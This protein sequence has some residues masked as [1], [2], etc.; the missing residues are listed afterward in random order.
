MAS[1]GPRLTLT[2]NRILSL[3][4]VVSSQGHFHCLLEFMKGGW[5]ERNSDTTLAS[6]F[7]CNKLGRDDGQEQKASCVFIEHSCPF[8]VHSPFRTRLMFSIAG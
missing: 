6:H 8:G 4:R 2:S 5:K 3:E 1:I 7:S